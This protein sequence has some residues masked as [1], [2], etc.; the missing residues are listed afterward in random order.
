LITDI[1]AT[2]HLKFIFTEFIYFSFVF[3]FIAACAP[4]EAAAP[5]ACLF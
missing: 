3:N 2:Q 5:Q 1:A 4:Q